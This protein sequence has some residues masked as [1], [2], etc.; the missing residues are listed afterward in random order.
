MK[1]IARGRWPRPQR[2]QHQRGIDAVFLGL[3][4]NPFVGP[5][6]IVKLFVEADGAAGERPQRIVQTI[7]NVAVGSEGQ[8]HGPDEHR[9]VLFFERRVEI[10][11]VPQAGAHPHQAQRARMDTPRC[12]LRRAASLRR[13]TRERAQ[14]PNRCHAATAPPSRCSLARACGRVSCGSVANHFAHFFEILLLLIDAF[15][16]SAQALEIE[17]VSRNSFQSRD[18]R[19][20]LRDHEIQPMAFEKFVPAVTAQLPPSRRKF[21]R[22]REH[23]TERTARRAWPPRFRRRAGCNRRSA[24]PKAA[25]ASED[26]PRAL[27]RDRRRSWTQATGCNSGTGRR[28]SP[29]R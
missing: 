2:L 29:S 28:D 18:E 27:A 22:A 26:R 20:K 25:R 19:M 1:Q 5:G 23:P 4:D 9:A 11:V 10:G 24:A 8:V 17:R 21:G 7:A 6:R 14:W 3:I 13:E 15:H 12:P 16:Q